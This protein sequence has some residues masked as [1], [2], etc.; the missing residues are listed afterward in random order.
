[1]WL[2][3]LRGVVRVICDWDVEEEW[4]VLFVT[5]IWEKS[6]ACCMWEGCL[7]KTRTT[8]F[9]Y[10]SHIQHAPLLLSISFTYNTHHSSWHVVCDGDASEEWCVLHVTGIFKRSGAWCMWLGYLRG[11]VRV[12]SDWDVSEE[13]SVLYVTGI[14]KRLNIQVTYNTHHSF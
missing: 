1:M 10:P 14:F 2:G 13:W 12:L 5:G 9:K 7:T 3:Y 6:G 4:C 8:P 11:V